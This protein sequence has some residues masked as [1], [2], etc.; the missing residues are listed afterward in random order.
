MSNANAEIGLWITWTIFQ[1]G[2]ND[3]IPLVRWIPNICFIYILVDVHVY[4][5]IYCDS[6]I[7]KVWH[8][9]NSYVFVFQNLN[10]YMSQN[11][12][13]PQ[14]ELKTNNNLKPPPSIADHQQYPSWSPENSFETS[15]S[16]PKEKHGAPQN[17]KGKGPYMAL[18]FQATSAYWD[19]CRYRTRPGEC[20][21]GSRGWD[22]TVG[23]GIILHGML[24]QFVS[25]FE[26]ISC[27]PFL[28]NLN[29]IGIISCKPFFQV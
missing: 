16:S 23:T 24:S 5:Y 3:K 26:I 19:L 10:K 13:S 15:S 9:G 14:V 18:L 8:M 25:H 11:G 28:D 2:V 27:Q 21:A 1:Y 7:W 29:G 12:S 6:M 22:S 17:S 4:I 20:R